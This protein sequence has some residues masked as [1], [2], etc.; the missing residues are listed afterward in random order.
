MKLTW[1][2]MVPAV[3]FAWLVVFASPATADEIV[4]D[5]EY[6]KS[7][8]QYKTEWDKEDKALQKRLA[9]LETKKGK[10][11]NIIFFMWDDAAYGRVG[12]PMLS[13]LTGIDTPNID[14]MA[15][16]GMILTRMYTE[17]SCT[18]TRVAAMTGR[19]PIRT[20]LTQVVFPVHAIGMPNEEVT[21]AELLKK[22]GYKTAFYGKYHVGDIDGSYPHQNGYDETLFTIYNQFGSQFFNKDGED[23]GATIGF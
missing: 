7:Y 12:H 3:L 19:H 8:N 21:I 18:P 16:E 10:R 17:P 5:A 2:K 9:A 14:K 1:I 11:P 20:G 23:T 22:E 4:Y 6:V 13:K 15:R